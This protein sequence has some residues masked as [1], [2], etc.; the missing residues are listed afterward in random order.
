MI[1]YLSN[2]SETVLAALRQHITLAL[3]PV[4]LGFLIALPIGYLGV[5]FPW[6]YH[7]LIN[8][9]GVLYSIPSLALFVFLPVVLGTKILS[10]LNIV[11][12]LTIYTVALMARTVADGLRSVDRLVVESATA[13]GYRRLRRLFDVELPVALPVILAGLRVAT[14]SN[15]S[16]VSVGALIGIGG[17]GQLFTR[18]FQLFYIE[19]I[20]VGIILSVLL[21]GIADLIIVLVQRAVTPWTRVQRGRA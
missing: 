17:L 19:P 4:L 8:V 11:V 13:M 18:G 20:L 12:A 9:A 1:T 14:V 16:L 5:R 6:L 10:P 21:A 2:N 15:I 3:I 7:P